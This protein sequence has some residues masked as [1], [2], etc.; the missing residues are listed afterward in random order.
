[1]GLIGRRCKHGN[2]FSRPVLISRGLN[3]TKLDG[4]R[5]LCDSQ[6]TNNHPKPK[7]LSDP[8]AGAGG[9]FRKSR[10]PCSKGLG[11]WLRCADGCFGGYS[12]G[13]TPGLIPNPEAKP[14]SADGTALG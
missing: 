1:M 12:G 14:S 11:C 3:H 4:L 9:G 8:Y 13:E 10:S 5:P 7:K 2:V 6:Q